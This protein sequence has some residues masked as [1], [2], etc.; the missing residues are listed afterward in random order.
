M[1]RAFSVC[2][3]FD[4]ILGGC[5]KLCMT[6]ALARKGGTRYPQ[7][8]DNETALTALKRCALVRFRYVRR[9]KIDFNRR[10]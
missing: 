10:R 3:A 1:N 9:G 2:F 6:R 4:Q 5:A 7:R 8:G